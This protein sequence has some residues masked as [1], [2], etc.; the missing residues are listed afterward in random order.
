MSDENSK[1]GPTRRYIFQQQDSLFSIAEAITGDS[2]NALWVRRMLDDMGALDKD[3]RPIPG[4]ILLYNDYV[5]ERYRN[6]LRHTKPNPDTHK[7][8]NV[9]EIERVIT[10]TLEVNP[11]ELPNGEYPGIFGGYE[12][13]TLIDGAPYRFETEH[14]IRTF[15]MPCTV[16]IKDGIVKIRY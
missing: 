14:G 2:A 5:L 16:I 9:K 11:R 8:I 3:G 13:V 12:V 7:Y 15:N 6:G 4:I 1:R 10:T